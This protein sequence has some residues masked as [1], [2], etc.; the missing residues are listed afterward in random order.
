MQPV[1]LGLCSNQ[2]LPWGPVWLT[3]QKVQALSAKLPHAL[4]I[5][6]PRTHSTHSPCSFL[7]PSPASP[8]C[9]PPLLPSPNLLIFFKFSLT[10]WSSHTL[11][12]SSILL[13]STHTLRSPK[14]PGP[15]LTTSSLSQ[16]P[17]YPTYP[18]S[19]LS[20]PL[21][22]EYPW[23]HQL[24]TWKCCLTKKRAQWGAKCMNLDGGQGLGPPATIKSCASLVHCLHYQFP[25]LGNET[26]TAGLV[27]R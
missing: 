1:L 24:L 7:F 8:P 3:E 14:A 21:L 15:A 17:S 12:P 26:R 19:L 13:A 23:L 2:L 4:L 16:D 11:H 20:S 9:T 25:H 18:G 10:Q 22:L 27:W 5:S 6:I